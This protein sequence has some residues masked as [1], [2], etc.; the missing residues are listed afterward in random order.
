MGYLFIHDAVGT[1]KFDRFIFLL[2]LCIHFMKWCLGEYKRDRTF[3]FSCETQAG[4]CLF[5]PP[6]TTTPTSY[7]TLAAH[8][9][10]HTKQ[11]ETEQKN[12][13]NFMKSRE[14]SRQAQIDSLIQKK[15]TVKT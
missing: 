9:V 6:T 13:S 8:T 3:S 15:S 10:T 1:F 2:P 12:H 14:V 5:C 11:K 4:P 7:N